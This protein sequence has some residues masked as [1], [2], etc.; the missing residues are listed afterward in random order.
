MQLVS[1][2]GTTEISGGVSLIVTF[3]ESKL[4]Q[5]LLSLDFMYCIDKNIC[6]LVPL[7]PNQEKNAEYWQCFHPGHVHHVLLH[8]HIWISDFLRWGHVSFLSQLQ[9]IA[10]FRDSEESQVIYTCVCAGNTEAELL[11]TYSKVDPLDTLIL[12]VRLAVLV[13]VT[14]TVPVVLFPVRTHL[15]F[16]HTSIWCTLSYEPETLFVLN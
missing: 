14:L 13:A 11:H 5:Q 9:N 7:K 12:C 4:Q 16:T 6:H 2:L 8:C 3:S 10:Q 15:V 1:H